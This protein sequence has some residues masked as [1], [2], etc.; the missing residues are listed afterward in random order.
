MLSSSFNQPFLGRQDL[1]ASFLCFLLGSGGSGGS[2]GGE[3]RQNIKM[4]NMKI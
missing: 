1:F 3:E 2:G 4:S